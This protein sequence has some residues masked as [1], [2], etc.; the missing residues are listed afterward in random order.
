MGHLLDKRVAH[1]PLI[2]WAQVMPVAY[3]AEGTGHYGC[4]CRVIGWIAKPTDLARIIEQLTPQ[5]GADLLEGMD[6]ARAADTLEELEDEQQGQIL[7][8]W[9]RSARRT[10]CRRWSQM[11]RR[12]RCRV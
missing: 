6:E 7:R 5:Q 11:R 4:A 2:D 12:T 8:R 3:G 10:S 9:I 1:G